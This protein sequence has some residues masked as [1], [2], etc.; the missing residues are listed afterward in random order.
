VTGRRSTSK[1]AVMALVFVVAITAER[2][3]AG[4]WI[5][6]DPNNHGVI[7]FV[8][9]ILGDERTTW[10]SGNAYWP[11][12]LTHDPTFDGQDIYVYHYPSPHLGQA[13]T[14]DEVAENMR[15][16]LTTDGVLQHTE[17]TFV[18]HSMGG[19]VTRAFILK[20]RKELVPKIRFLFFFATPTSGTPYALLGGLVSSNPQFKELYPM[21]PD[22]YLA[23]L[24][25]NWL[26][27]GMG[28]KSFCAYETQTI[29]GQFVVDLPSASNLCT[30]PLDPISADH[31]NIV[32]PRDQN[33]E[34]YL[35]LKEAFL[36]TTPPPSTLPSTPQNA[37]TAH[38]SP[39]EPAPD[40]RYPAP[41]EYLS[42]WG[43][44]DSKP[45]TLAISPGNPPQ[46]VD[47]NAMSK[48]EVY[49]NLL[50]KWKDRYKV[51]AVCFF[52]DGKQDPKD[53]T[54][55]SKSA[56]F[57]IVDS[58]IEIV[59]PWNDQFLNTLKNGAKGTNYVLLLLPKDLLPSQFDSLRE[60]TDK[61]AVMM[62]RH[63]GP[64]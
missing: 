51:A 55:I 50:R 5:R 3:R 15:S 33:G 9:G 11:E 41:V 1:L 21:D 57:D 42:S 48:L 7:V 44:F 37:K 40:E 58:I 16:V 24:L 17:I 49:G 29:Y 13:F 23:P 27:A 63:G 53:T 39:K 18:S 52:Y 22:S 46:V 10:T 34:Q 32:K 35:A 45:I 19:I 12:M 60:A 4:T 30:E 43:S 59:I 2:A 36:K 26:A 8:H 6:H 64:P 54:G 62:E 56:A 38:S 14:I 47:G 20:Y 28:L 31:F 25:R 61:G